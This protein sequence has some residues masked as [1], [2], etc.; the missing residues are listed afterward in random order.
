[1]PAP[2]HEQAKVAFSDKEL[3]YLTAAA[4]ASDGWNRVA[5][6]LRFLPRDGAGRADLLPGGSVGMV[7]TLF[8]AVPQEPAG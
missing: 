8:S 3:A 5:V 7:A 6:A 4:V 2:V 1:M